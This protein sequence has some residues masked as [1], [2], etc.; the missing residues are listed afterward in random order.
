MTRQPRDIAGRLERRNGGAPS[1]RQSIVRL[2]QRAVSE[3]GTIEGY[4]SVFGVVDD[5]GDIVAPGAFAASLTAHRAAGTMP[6]MLWQH[7][8]SEPIGV[9]TEMAEDSR[10]LRIKGRLVLESTRGREAYALLK[11]GAINGLSIGFVAR[12]WAWDNTTDIRT[13]QEVDLWEVSPVTFPAN[14]HARVDGVKSGGAIT[15]IRDAERALRDA[16]LSAEQAKATLASVKR[17]VQTERDAESE[18]QRVIRAAQQLTES[19]TRAAS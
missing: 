7:R 18:L 9:W 4:G 1:R 13:L 12:K 19:M 14:D 6:A 11:A 2:E 15:T 5:W 17:A 16:G 10:G 3:D 8:D